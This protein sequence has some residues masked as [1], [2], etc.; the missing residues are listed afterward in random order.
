MN[1]D[2]TG[3]VFIS[4]RRTRLAE[5][6]LLIE[7]LHDRGIPTWQDLANIG[8][9]Q[10]EAE[11]RKTL[12]HP[13]ISGAILW[14][15]PDVSDQTMV[16]LV[17]LPEID[18]RSFKDELFFAQL[19]AAGGLT[20]EQVS[21]LAKG[22][23]PY[24]MGAFNIT[25]VKSNPLDFA[26]AS[27]VA[28]LTLRHRIATLHRELPV[29]GPL[30]VEIN[31]WTHPA[32]E[33]GKALIID[34]S[35]RFENGRHAKPG[36]WEEFVLAALQDIAKTIQT[37]AP[38]RPIEARGQIPLPAAVAL[39]YTFLEPNP[40]NI[41]WRPRHSPEQL[42]SIRGPRQ[43]SGF[44]ATT[45]PDRL[46][47]TD[48]AVLVS[49]DNDVTSAFTRSTSHL[50]TKFRA[51]V[52]VSNPQLPQGITRHEISTPE[53]ARDIAMVVRQE[54][55]SACNKFSEIRCAHLFLAVPVGLAMMIGQV[56]NPFP[57]IQTYEYRNTTGYVLSV[58][59]N[60]TQ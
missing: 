55:V 23:T 33:P 59:L 31:S 47:A 46:D 60:Q 52:E 4:Y 30:I 54:V 12:H 48:L 36:I 6:R 7:A 19:V 16:R 21:D 10:A 53:E 42:W 57:T 9:G 18:T 3:R 38:G 28:R 24:D 35:H 11:L 58:R 17:E 8:M 1:T 43:E 22:R 2:P 50:N 27:R 49:V 25:K 20:Y 26:E 37:E 40:T 34:W 41:S 14:L 56:M 51:I 5:I 15:T 13:L 45:R 29:G 39:G 32:F 44:L